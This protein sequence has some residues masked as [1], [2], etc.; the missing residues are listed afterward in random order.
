M[1]RS[2]RTLTTYPEN[3]DVYRLARLGPTHVFDLA[4]ARRPLLDA[5]RAVNPSAF[6]SPD[7]AKVRV[8]VPGFSL[9][10][11]SIGT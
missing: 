11:G 8:A 6:A 9:I 5:D 2:P 4:V 3:A 7:L 10:G 1:I